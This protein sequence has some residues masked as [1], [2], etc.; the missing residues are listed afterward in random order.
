MGSMRFAVL[1]IVIVEVMMVVVQV[2]MIVVH[3]G[4]GQIVQMIIM[5]V[6]Q[7]VMIV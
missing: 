7:F 4:H 2:I 6:D 5:F 3:R 1:A